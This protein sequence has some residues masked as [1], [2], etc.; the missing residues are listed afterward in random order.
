MRAA[1][2]GAALAL[3]LAAPG[4]AADPA[5]PLIGAIEAAIARAGETPRAAALPDAAAAPLP[6]T[7]IAPEASPRPAPRPA[8][9]ARPAPETRP[10]PA[11]A[12]EVPAAPAAPAA[13]SRPVPRPAPAPVTAAADLPA[14]QAAPAVSSRP[15]PRAGRPEAAIPPATVA[16]M[17]LPPRA[18]HP[19]GAE[20]CDDPRLEGARIPAISSPNAACGIPQP[21][22]IS[23]VAG[24]RLSRPITVNCRMAVQLADWVEYAAIPASE[25]IGEHLALITTFDSYSCRPRNNKRG[26][27]LS[28]H[29]R[30]NA[31]DIAG[32]V[33]ASGRQVTVLEGWKRSS[34][35]P[36][37]KT[38]HARACGLFGTVLG[39]NADPYHRNHFHLDVA[40]RRA[41][42]CR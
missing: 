13:S 20:I 41:G 30:G 2:A 1:L 8:R 35:S 39:P 12:A 40:E 42:Y 4:R 21:V 26:N 37:L 36:F 25:A 10:P 33:F 7:A 19:P 3:L 28:E 14:T 32:F 23:H 27:R 22:R 6:A 31:V 18:I 29:G 9:I 34:E 38:L 15:R 17:N 24:V 5:D 11:A 16:A